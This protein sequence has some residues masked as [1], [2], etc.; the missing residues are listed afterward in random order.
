MGVVGRGRKRDRVAVACDSQ[1][2]WHGLKPGDAA[3]RSH[4]R[5]LCHE[6]QSYRRKKIDTGIT[7]GMRLV[8]KGK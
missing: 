3:V 2:E 4:F 6:V 5:M 7:T 1:E 8:S